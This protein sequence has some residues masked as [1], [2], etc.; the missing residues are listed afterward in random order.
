MVGGQI[1]DIRSQLE[2]IDF[3]G[4]KQMHAM[5]TGALIGVSVN[6]AALISQANPE[7]SLCLKNYGELLGL[8]FQLAD[9][10]LDAAEEVEDEEVS[11]VSCLGED[12]TKSYLAEVTDRAMSELKIFGAGAEHLRDLCLYNQSRTF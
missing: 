12:K 10:L 4:L 1:I 8:A 2:K 9:D 7:Q 5:K 6:G 11:F 3:D